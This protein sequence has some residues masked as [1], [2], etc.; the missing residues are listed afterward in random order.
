MLL[1]ENSLKAKRKFFSFKRTSQ[2][3]YLLPEFFP[4]LDGRGSVLGFCMEKIKCYW[5]N[6][7]EVKKKQDLICSKK[8]LYFSWFWES[9]NPISTTQSMSR[10]YIFLKRTPLRKVAFKTFFGISLF[11]RFCWQCLLSQYNYILSYLTFFY[12]PTYTSK[13]K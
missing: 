4:W 5:Y 1:L 10:V 6:L 9:K 12:I 11:Q 13:M 7:Q 8:N 2:I 3:K